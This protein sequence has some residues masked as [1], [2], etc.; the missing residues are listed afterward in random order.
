MNIKHE[1][2]WSKEGSLLHTPDNNKVINQSTPGV[3]L[4]TYHKKDDS[5]MT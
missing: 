2:L 5:I 4:H 3:Q 1:E